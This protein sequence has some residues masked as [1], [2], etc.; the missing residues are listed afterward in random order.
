MPIANDAARAFAASSGGTPLNLLVESAGG[1]SVTAHILGGAVIGETAGEGVV[2]ANHEI[3]G[4]PDLFVADAAAIPVNLGVNPSLTITAMAERFADRWPEKKDVPPVDMPELGTSWPRADL[5]TSLTGL[6]RLWK[7]LPAPAP[8]ALPGTHRAVFIGPA[9]LRVAAPLGLGL[10]GLPG[11]FG[12]RFERDVQGLHGVN[13][14]R[15][16]E[17]FR[18][19]LEMRAT[20]GPSRLDGAPALVVTYGADAPLPWRHIRDELRAAGTGALLGMTVLDLP[21]ARSIGTPFLLERAGAGR[22]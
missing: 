17:G 12:K 3:H 9:V 14:L 16:G 5:P 1:R 18:E 8:E 7:A 19:H 2:D 20:L 4:H 13:L 22:A 6:A 15:D 11:W 21:G 10:L